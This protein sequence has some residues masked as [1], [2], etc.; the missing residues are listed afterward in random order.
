MPGDNVAARDAFAAR[1]ATLSKAH[2]VLIQTNWA[3]VP[4]AVV[5]NGAL[6]A[7]GLSLACIRTSL[8]SW[9]WG[10]NSYGTCTRGT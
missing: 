4:I 9:S 7:H 1:S 8:P 2:D 10:L 3:N 5:V 6:A